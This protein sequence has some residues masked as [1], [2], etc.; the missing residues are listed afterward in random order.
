MNKKP[1]ITNKKRINISKF[2]KP[3]KHSKNNL[4]LNNKIK[5]NT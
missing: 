3:E 5:L 2:E 4:I 1:K